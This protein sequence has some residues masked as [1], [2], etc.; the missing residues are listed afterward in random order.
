M[1]LHKLQPLFSLL[2]TV[3]KPIRRTRLSEKFFWTGL[4]LILYLI[5]CEVPLYGVAVVGPDPFGPA[6]IIFAATR[7]TLMELGIGPIITAGLILQV[8]VGAG[9]I[10]LDLSKPRDRALFTSASKFLAVVFTGISA[11]AL[12]LLFYPQ[13]AAI[14]PPIATI[15]FLQL[16]AAGILVILMDELV[17]KGWGL[18]SG[19]SLFIVAGV[20]R[21]IA[22]QCFSPLP[23][24]P[25][26]D[27]D[28]KAFGL[29]P[30]LV[31]TWMRGEAIWDL[32]V[33]I[34]GLPA[35]S[36]LVAMILVF[37]TII[38]L[39]GIR[40]EI[41]IAH[42]RVR[43]FRARF[44]IKLLYVSVIP[45]IFAYALAMQLL[46]LAQILW[47]QLGPE[48]PLLRYICVFEGGVLTGGLIYY[49]TPPYSLPELAANP[50]RGMAYLLFMVVSCIAFSV[51][52][53]QLSRMDA[54]SVA[55]Q[56]IDGGMLVPGYRRAEQAVVSLLD[57]YISPITV[58]SGGLIG[59]IAAVSDFT[60]AFGTGLGILLTVD[61]LYNYYQLLMRE[62]IAEAYP[63]L[64]P[65]FGR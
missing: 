50:L 30:A 16:M 5:M 60:G 38:Y 45:A 31:E 55:K 63:A 24:P 54:R 8:L 34:G 20:T 40:V 39:R 62:R 4:V 48:N 23:A 6:R 61:I 11:A 47:A 14:T 42:F 19:I 2:P 52:W 58:L 53:V 49:L 26:P 15:I 27:G 35:L 64:A 33:R 46:F 57:R 65:F 37:A 32:F 51:I 12:V 21:E 59:L 10:K 41:P 9:W 18:G 44:P 13:I 36:G 28:G 56:L 7:G 25:P 22:W 29:F 1:S 43:G 17:Q 3:V